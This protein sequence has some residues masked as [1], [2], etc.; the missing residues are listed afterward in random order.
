MSKNGFLERLGI[1]RHAIKKDLLFFF[2]PWFTL[3]YMELIFCSKYGDGVSGIWGII[4]ELVKHPQKLFML[5][6]QRIIGL[7]LFIIGLTIMIVGQATLWKNYS[8][9]LIIRKGHQLIT[10]GIY[11]FT[12][13]PIYLGAIMVFTGLPV[14]AASLY[15]FLTMLLI[16]PIILNRIRL[17][18]NLLAEE[19]QD[20]YQK[21]KQRTKKLIPFIY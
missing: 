11:R 3:F 10:H 2:L 8:G 14:Y 20:A 1:A 12:R 17:E 19:F 7:A 13:N 21:Y 15:G 9:F 4:W 6:L 16:I 5:P 18:E